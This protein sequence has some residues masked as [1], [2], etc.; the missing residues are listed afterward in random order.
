MHDGGNT[1][2]RQISGRG[3]LALVAALLAWSPLLVLPPTAVAAASAPAPNAPCTP[4][5]PNSYTEYRGLSASDECVAGV[6]VRT[7]MKLQST[8]RGDASK[9]C[10]TGDV[11][12]GQNYP[13]SGACGQG[14]EAIAQARLINRA[15]NDPDVRQQLGLTWTDQNHADGGI[16]PGIQWE[17]RLLTGTQRQYPDFLVFDPTHP[18]AVVRIAEVKLQ[19]RENASIA[20]VYD[21]QLRPYVA[22]WKSRLNGRAEMLD[23]GDY[24]DRFSICG[25]EWRVAREDLT[26]G[27]K[28]SDFRA[29]EGDV[30]ALLVVSRVN[31]N[32]D[33]A[34]VQRMM[35]HEERLDCPMPDSE[36]TDGP[37]G[38]DVGPGDP[39]PDP[40]SPDW[41]NDPFAGVQCAIDVFSDQVTKL[42]EYQL[43]STNQWA[44]MRNI[45]REMD[46]QLE[47]PI[48]ERCPDHGGGAWG[49]PHLTSLDGM[50]F[51]V[52]SLG[53]FQLLSASAVGL[54]LQGR[55]ERWGNTQA[56]IMTAVAFS[57]NGFAV[58]MDDQGG[59][60]VDGRPYLLENDDSL[61]FNGGAT[62]VRIDGRY[63]VLSPRVQ[64][65]GVVFSWGG[66]RLRL[67]AAPG[68]TTSGMLGDHDGNPGNDL[69]TRDG[70]MPDAV[71]AGFLHGRFAESWRISQ[72]DS[73]F[74]YETGESTA[75]FTDRT[76]PDNV[77]D[78]SDFPADEVEDAFATCASVEEGSAQDACALDVLVTGTDQFLDDA[79][80]A[81]SAPVSALPLELDDSG[82]AVVDFNTTVP[83]NF[84]PSRRMIVDG[85]G[86]VAGPL[87]S[88]ATYRFDLPVVAN[89][90]HVNVGMDLVVKG[91]LTVARSR[92]LELNLG[93]QFTDTI[94]FGRSGAVAAEGIVTRLEDGETS[95]G[96]PWRRYRYSTILPAASATLP[97]EITALGWSRY[98]SDRIGISHLEFALD[99]PAPAPWRDIAIDQTLWPDASRTGVD[100]ILSTRGER[101]RYR[102]SLNEPTRLGL[103]AVDSRDLQS[104]CDTSILVHRN[105]GQRLPACFDPVDYEDPDW[106]LE[107]GD[108][109]LRVAAP[110]DAHLPMKYGVSLF[111][112]AASQSFGAI[113]DDEPVVFQPSDGTGAGILSA[114]TGHD[115]YNLSVQRAG[116]LI[117][118]VECIEP[119]SDCLPYRQLSLIPPPQDG[120]PERIMIDGNRQSAFDVGLGNYELAVHS[121]FGYREYKLTLRVIPRDVQ[122]IDLGQVVRP[123]ASGVGTLTEAHPIDRFRFSIPAG[124][125]MTYLD[126]LDEYQT[127][128]PRSERLTCS[129][130]LLRDA[131]GNDLDPCM[132]YGAWLDEGDY[133]LTVRAPWRSDLP[134]HYGFVFYSDQE[135]TNQ[136][137]NLTETGAPELSAA[138]G[139]HVTASTGSGIGYLNNSMSRDT[140]RF[141]A[142][143]AGTPVVMVACG[144]SAS[145]VPLSDASCV[146]AWMTRAN[147]WRMGPAVTGGLPP[148]WLTLGVDGSQAA[149]AAT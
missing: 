118:E 91:A 64:N 129:F 139:L 21:R 85:V 40:N 132:F 43:T 134:F 29:S 125:A 63:V 69:Q 61:Y 38:D 57:L 146:S 23:V 112:P 50:A 124:G 27:S 141:T 32:S 123:S 8:A 76:F 33:S 135:V 109:E 106:A 121:T 65:R 133:E 90:A 15:N 93:Q 60:W 26:P 115:I 117:V 10:L 72:S 122:D 67:L 31:S 1:V 87:P 110:E 47:N 149:S 79:L 48:S 53:E 95:D 34:S 7:R 94:T 24:E 143:Q 97:G 68:L 83:S 16:D 104:F 77:V 62:I 130:W 105:S 45:G 86:E 89:H 99:E 4:G 92:S 5:D 56:S 54:D 28:E 111:S 147:D 74:T 42:V 128:D 25:V 120:V 2:S 70:E 35:P 19:K 6:E 71:S 144:P 59:L 17:P 73:L 66:H 51:D 96:I 20:N 78:F 30:N 9:P 39:N 3:W 116:T 138:N 119:S 100:G 103:G 131:N 142:G 113:I 102:F 58:E 127:V 37:V 140:Y 88:G 114:P 137:F 11:I 145:P 148:V 18:D 55:F 75:T 13:Y 41:D 81:S 98:Q 108:Y 136:Q 101:E 84:A 12:E 107:P 46:D 49:D 80:L 36:D 126:R 22:W 52:Q 82:P 14:P 44:I